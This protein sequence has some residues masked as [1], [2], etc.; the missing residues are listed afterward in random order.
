MRFNEILARPKYNAVLRSLR[1][2]D[3]GNLVYTYYDPVDLKAWE[4]TFA[5]FSGELGR[6]MGVGYRVS[7]GV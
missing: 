2:E 5:Y 1:I 4:K 7:V 3:D 6:V